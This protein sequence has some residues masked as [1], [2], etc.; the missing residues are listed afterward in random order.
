[1]KRTVITIGLLF[2][3]LI[4]PLLAGCDDK[5]KTEPAETESSPPILAL[6]SITPTMAEVK[7][8]ET[9]HFRAIAAYSDGSEE[10]VTEKVTW[11]SS[12]PNVAA[13]SAKGQAEGKSE[14]EV[15]LTATLKGVVGSATLTVSPARNLSGL[16]QSVIFLNPERAWAKSDEMVQF[17]ATLV[18]TDGTWED[19]TS[20]VTWESSDTGSAIPGTGGLIEAKS[21]G[22]A[23][24]TATQGDTKGSALLTV[25]QPTLESLVSLEVLAPSERQGLG[26]TVQF[27]AVATYEEGYQEIVTTEVDWGS[28]DLSVATVSG[29]GLVEAKS[30]GSTTLSISLAGKTASFVLTVVTAVTSVTVI[31][32]AGTEVEVPYPVERI[33]SLNP[34]ALEVIC[35]LD[36]KNRVVGVDQFSKWNPE[37]YPVLKTRPSV[38]M[39]MG[40]PPNYEKIIELRPQVVV[41]YADPMWYYPDLEEKV[42]AAGVKVLRL[43]CYKPETF[44]QDVEVLGTILG[45]EARADQYLEFIEA[46]VR[47]IEERV[48]SIPAAEKVKVYFEWFTPYV[49]Y[50]AKSGPDQLITRAGGRNIYEGGG[51]IV[52]MPGYDPEMSGV[53]S[54]MSPEWLVQQNADVIIKDYIDME[55]MMKMGQ[56]PKKTGYTSEP[57]PSG[58]AKGQE[59]I[60]NRPGWQVIK[61][62]E[63]GKVYIFSFGELASSPRWAVGLSYMAKWFYPDLFEDLDPQAFHADWLEEWHGLEAQ[64]VFVYP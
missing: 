23:T 38:G 47:E 60:E 28:S 43:D 2:L 56:E 29:T 17:S 4:A 11:E 39:P 54:L 46:S 44:A 57:D 51:E 50:G 19:V 27:G 42:E 63:E 30:E 45:K 7:V 35:A 52:T 13:L 9:L 41:S 48:S 49:A 31:D 53:Y 40:M 36:A 64:G 33:A 34:A 32:A 20:Q 37:F 6:I 21:A 59:E 10:E 14:G 24:I 61:A 3:C 1:M 22:T 15:T 25:V 18:R 12:N 5:E 16:T 62:V 58:L 8:G 26:N 55:S